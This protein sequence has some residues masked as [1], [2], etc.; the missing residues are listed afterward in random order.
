VLPKGWASGATFTFWF[1]DMTPTRWLDG[2]RPV[3]GS[4]HKVYVPRYFWWDPGARLPR[5]G[6]PTPR[7]AYQQT[8]DFAG[9][10]FLKPVEGSDFVRVEYDMRASLARHPG[11]KFAKDDT[12][13]Y[14]ARD[15]APF[16]AFFH[17]TKYQCEGDVL[18][19]GL[20]LQYSL[21]SSNQ[22]D[23]G[24][25]IEA[26]NELFAA[27]YLPKTPSAESKR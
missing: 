21:I 20:N 25:V 7:E 23:I 22:D 12:V 26:T 10:P 14:I 4:R 27:W 13:T 8:V 16:E 1:P 6:G 11:Y 19:K 15:G 2:H 9:P 17:C 3:D 24:K 5:E 18:V